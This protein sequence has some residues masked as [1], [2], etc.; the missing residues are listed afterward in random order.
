M[1]E[2]YFLSTTAGELARAVYAQ[3]RYAEAEELTRLA[4]EL[5]ADDDLT[6][7]A[8]WRSVRAKALARRSLE[9]DAQELARKAVALLEGTDALIRQADALE[10]LA[11]VLELAGADGARECLNEALAIFERKED[12]VSVVRVRALLRT[13]EAAAV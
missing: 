2:R 4:E 1:G 11:E 9:A 13:L 7:Q 6:S 12:V 3:G 10:D 5:S 8:L